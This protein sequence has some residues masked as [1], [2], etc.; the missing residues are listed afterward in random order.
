MKKKMIIFC[1]IIVAIIVL[2]SCASSISANKIKNIQSPE[3]VNI[4]VNQYYNTPNTIETEVSLEEAEEI[5]EILTNLNEAITNNDEEAISYYEKQLNNKGIF[6]DDYQ[7]FYSNE[8]YIEALKSN[9][10]SKLFDLLEDKNGE[11]LSNLLCYFNAIGNGLFVSYLAT[12]VWEAF[13]RIAGNASSF[14]ELFV[15]IILFLPFVAATVVL[16]GLIPF[17]IFMPNGMVYMEKG[18]ISSIGLK[19]WKRANVEETNP[20]ILN[21]SWFTGLSVSIPGNEEAGRDNFCF[22]SGIAVRVYESES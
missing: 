7:E 16:T 2:G 21:L 9:K 11:D 3:N 17:R 19:G 1:T 4:L 8:E 5:K 14:L 6:G 20:V 22:V 13:A 15:I 10:N 18:R 12:L